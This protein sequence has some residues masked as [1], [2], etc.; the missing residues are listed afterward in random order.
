MVKRRQFAKLIASGKTQTEAALIVGYPLASASSRGY[1]LAKDPET[2]RLI[3]IELEKQGL[4]DDIFVA[5]L[6][7]GLEAR[8]GASADHKTRHK[9]WHD[10]GKIRG[11]IKESQVTNNHLNVFASEFDKLYEQFRAKQAQIPG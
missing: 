4:T 2:R 8:Q 11:H 7:E 10:W 3:D 5:K 9:Y 1:E 6:K